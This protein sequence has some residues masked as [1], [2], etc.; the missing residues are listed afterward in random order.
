LNHKSRFSLFAF[1]RPQSLNWM[2]LHERHSI[3]NRTVAP[4]VRPHTH[5]LVHI[6]F[7]CLP[8]IFSRPWHVW[9][10]DP[11][12][13]TK[14]L[15]CSSF[16]D[17][18]YQTFQKHWQR[19]WLCIFLE[20]CKK[21]DD[22]QISL[23]PQTLSHYSNQM[24]SQESVIKTFLCSPI[25]QLVTKPNFCPSINFHLNWSLARAVTDKLFW[26]DCNWIL[27]LPLSSRPDTKRITC[28]L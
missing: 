22:K 4:D 13:S 17:S 23:A 8:S 2:N 19:S 27:P 14:R 21:E 12:W 16:F 3:V 20:L 6:L 24:K 18:L 25:S 9:T 10:P 7:T 28:N 5:S 15:T 11:T 1:I 26:A